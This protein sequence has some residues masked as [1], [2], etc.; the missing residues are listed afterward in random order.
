MCKRK[1]ISGDA[2]GITY[3]RG[4]VKHGD[5]RRKIDLLVDSGATYTVLKKEV[6]EYLG[7]GP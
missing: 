2:L 4:I 3:V 7:L 1:G 5:R 6:W